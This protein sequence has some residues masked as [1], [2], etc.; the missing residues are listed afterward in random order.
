P[1]EFFA[2]SPNMGLLGVVSAITFQCDDTFNITGQ[3]AVSTVAGC[4]I[5]LLGAGSHG[6]PSLEQFLRDAEYA[7][8]EWWPQRGVDRVLAWQAQQIRPQLGF[9]PT[10][11]EEFTDHPESAEVLMSIFLTIFGNLDDLSQAKPK[12]EETFD[13]LQEALELLYAQKDLGWFGELLAKV[14]SRVAE[15][16]VDAAI[17]LLEPAAPLIKR[18][19]PDIFP[20]LVGIFVSLD[21]DKAGMQKGEPQA[22]RDYGWQGLP[23]DNQA[24]DVLVPTEFTE[25]WI[26]LPRTQQAM[27]VLQA[28]FSEPKDDGDSYRRTGTYVWELYAAMPARFWMAASHTA[29]DDEWRDGAFRVDVYW[30]GGN[31]GDPAETFFPPLWQLM[32]DNGIPFRLHWGKFQP[33]YE[34]G[35][36]T[37]VDFFRAH[38]PRWDD[39]LALRE[40]RDPNNIFLNGYW[41]DR[42]GLWDAPQPAP[43]ST[44]SG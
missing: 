30:F 22:F 10:R 19:L 6:R 36:R 12:L 28:W 7:R 11:Y 39:F 25:L 4:A 38:Y 44:P 14:L 33:A 23:M 40:R 42:F 24:N 27:E 1:D 2:M 17:T 34:A 16:G 13:Q 5:D 32:R 15:G 31:A 26:P 8:V 43:T 9:R 35:D 21:D 3:E 20:K 37:W 41:R 29:G 18:A